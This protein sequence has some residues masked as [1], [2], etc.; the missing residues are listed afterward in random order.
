VYSII[1]A[2]Y[3]RAAVLSNL[4]P[5]CLCVVPVVSLAKTAESSE[6]DYFGGQTC[7]GPTTMYGEYD[8]TILARAAMRAVS[9]ITQQLFSFHCG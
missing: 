9:I 1:I 6:M 5:N 8:R 4:A 3:R 2:Y 7:V